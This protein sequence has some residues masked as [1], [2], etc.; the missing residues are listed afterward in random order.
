[1]PKF[2]KSLQYLPHAAMMAVGGG[3]AYHYGVGTIENRRLQKI[4]DEKNMTRREREQRKLAE[5]TEMS[6]YGKAAIGVAGAAVGYGAAKSVSAGYRGIRNLMSKNK[7][8]TM[9]GMRSAYGKTF[10]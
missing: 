2:T 10:G 3:A 7:G 8:S 4:K 5:Q 6:I 1:M 9:D